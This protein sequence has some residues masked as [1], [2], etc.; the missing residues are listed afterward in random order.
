MAGW[1]VETHRLED[2]IRLLVGEQVIKCDEPRILGD[3]LGVVLRVICDG[4]LEDF[5]NVSLRHIWPLG[6]YVRTTV[7]GVR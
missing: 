6:R 5:V 4:A 2:A 3:D 7:I 1:G